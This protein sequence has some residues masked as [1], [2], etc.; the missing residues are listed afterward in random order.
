MGDLT[1]LEPRRLWGYF[2]ELSRIPR[3]SKN[4]AAAG[5]SDPSTGSGRTIPR[6]A[7]HAA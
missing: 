1:S 2:L 6:V 4:E 5:D 7:H 3:G